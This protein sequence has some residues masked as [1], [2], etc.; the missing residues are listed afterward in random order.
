MFLFYVYFNLF[1]LNCIFQIVHK[2]SE[3]CLERPLSSGGVSQHAGKLQLVPCIKKWFEAHLWVATWNGT[4]RDGRTYP[5]YLMSDESMCVD[6]LD[7]EARAMACSGLSKQL[8]YH[9]MK[10][11]AIVHGNT[12]LCLSVSRPPEPPGISVHT[13][14]GSSEQQ[15]ILQS[16]SWS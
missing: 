10:S 11:N 16:E 3:K 7:G 12:G 8:W 5:G 14:D 9:N 2:S 6:H 13:C 1:L 15:W 4:Q